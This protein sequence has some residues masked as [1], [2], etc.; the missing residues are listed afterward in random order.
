MIGWSEI[1]KNTAI[2]RYFMF[3]IR[4]N[5]VQS[6]F[7]FILELQQLIFKEIS[8]T[9]KANAGEKETGGSPAL[10]SFGK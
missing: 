7:I 10:F 4:Q 3:F 8:V 5:H 1:T 2:N 9:F 6:S